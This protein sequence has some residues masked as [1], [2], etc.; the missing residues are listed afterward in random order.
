MAIDKGMVLAGAAAAAIIVMMLVLASPP[1]PKAGEMNLPL[2]AQPG[3]ATPPAN[4][5]VQE[6]QAAPKMNFT[7]IAGTGIR[8]GSDT[9]P[10]VMVE[11]SDYQCPFCRRFWLHNYETLR[12]EYVDTGKVQLVYRDFPLSFHPAAE[13][14]AEAVACA[15]DQQHGWEFHDKIFSEQAKVS[16]GTVHYTE[17]DLKEWATELGLNRTAF[18]DC[19]DSGKYAPAVTQ[20]YNEAAALGISGTP[21]F[22]IGKR[23]GSNV[24]PIN[25]ALPYGTF[26]ATIDQLLQ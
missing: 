4:A 11:F 8:I 22:I 6:P 12:K 24:V 25:G 14:S 7:R 18:D 17:T 15:E 2:P 23:S 9:A 3:A 5:T 21:S 16:T 20:S 26:K 13:I 1:S 19:L 10:V